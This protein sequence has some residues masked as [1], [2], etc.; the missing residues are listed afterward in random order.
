[1]VDCTPKKI[2]AKNV[3]IYRRRGIKFIV[4]GGEKHSVTGH[5]FVAEANYASALGRESTRVVSCNTTS[6]V[7][8]LTAL[9]RVGL[10]R[11]ARGTLL[12]RA[13]DP[14][15]S[16]MDG[17]INTAVPETKVPSHQGPD[18]QTVLS[19]LDITTMAGAGPFNLSHLHF[20]M[21]ETTR[22][23]TL[24]ELRH[25]LWEEPRIAFVR[26][27]DGLVSLSSVVELMR[28]LGRPRNDM[29]EV[30]VWEDALAVDERE[31]YLTFQVHNEAI[32]VP[33]NVDAIRALIGIERDG[34]LQS[35]DFAHDRNGAVGG[36][37]E[38]KPQKAVLEY[39]W[40]VGDLAIARLETVAPGIGALVTH[41][42]LGGAT[43]RRMGIG[44]GMSEPV[45]VPEHEAA[46]QRSGQGAVNRPAFTTAL[47][48][49]CAQRA[50]I[51][52]AAASL[53]ARQVRTTA[54]RFRELDDDAPI[55][56]DRGVAVDLRVGLAVGQLGVLEAHGLH[57][58]RAC[59]LAVDLEVVH[60]E[61]LLAT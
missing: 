45:V 55:G 24:T 49:E 52:M 26:S 58:E 28:D 30:A 14:W 40:L 25:A 47:V 39:L 4:E 15:E 11:R 13:T 50:G 23:V 5:S 8:T 54:V 51:A 32:V 22:P 41:R 43:S 44:S 20:A 17:M 37:W 16:H 42:E 56:K 46:G 10:L 31:V 60:E 19:E 1:V 27:G 18:A 9:K 2:A 57:A 38:W 12:R 36:W 59:S 3:E 21:V 33:E 48:E 6:V 53:Y 34:P 7:R 61:T 35:R 29:W